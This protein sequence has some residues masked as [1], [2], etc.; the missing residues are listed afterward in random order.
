VVCDLLDAGSTAAAVR[1]AEPEVVINA[2][3]LSDVD[4]C[5]RDPAAAEALN[6]RA[7]EHLS[8]A[9]RGVG[10]RLIHVSTDYV[11][12]GTA[13]RPYDEQD[14]VNPLGVYGRTKLA[15]ERAVLDYERATVARTSTLFGLGRGSF[16]DTVV[17]RLR[18]G[19]WLQ[20]FHDQTTSPTY[21]D[22]LAEGLLALAE[23]LGRAHAP[24]RVF[25]VVN[26]GGCT[27]V[28][29]AQAI[30]KAL[31]VSPE[32]IEPIPMATQRRPAPRPAFSALTSRYLHSYLGRTLRPWQDALLAYLRQRRWIA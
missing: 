8:E 12:D 30:A 18:A 22:D 3:A 5:E 10:A 7:T 28:E 9:A 31:G 2:Q 29:F 11:F 32:R 1:R 24:S 15:G 27:R 16:C 19:E 17:E 14:P 6:V 21:A 4:A 13:Q 23:A 25:H 26:A 20:A